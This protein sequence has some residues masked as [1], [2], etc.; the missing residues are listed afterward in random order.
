VANGHC[1]FGQDGKCLK[2]FAIG[3]SPSALGSEPRTAVVVLAAA[4][5]HYISQNLPCDQSGDIRY[6]F[7]NFFLTIFF[8]NLDVEII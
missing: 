7:F 3:A 5:H 4:T 8:K 6:V 1:V 2:L